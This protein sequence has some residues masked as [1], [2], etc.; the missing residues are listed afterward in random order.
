VSR[1]HRGLE[2]RRA[3]SQHLRA[4]RRGAFGKHGDRLAACQSCRDV[5]IHAQQVAARAALDTFSFPSG[6]TLH[7]VAFTLVTLAYWPWLASLLVPFTLLTA[8]SRVVLGLHYPS[9]VLAGALIGA[10]VALASLAIA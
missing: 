10:S 5:L 8:A 1:L 4:V 7:A 9:D 6:H 3:E 2:Q